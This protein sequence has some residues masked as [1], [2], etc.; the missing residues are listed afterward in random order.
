MVGHPT[1][2]NIFTGLLK[3]GE[4]QAS[5]A[6]SP[7][8]WKVREETQ[9]FA[10]AI[11]DTTQPEASLSSSV[12]AETVAPPRRYSCRHPRRISPHFI[13]H[14]FRASATGVAVGICC[15]QLVRNITGNPE[16]RDIYIHNLLHP[17]YSFSHC[18]SEKRGF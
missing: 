10:L 4:T 11:P 1:R 9:K 17:S 18:K 13:K 16:V 8:S 6:A 12:R 3:E 15:L 7:L 14:I 5:E 2:Q